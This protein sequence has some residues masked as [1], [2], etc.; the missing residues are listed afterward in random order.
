[1]KPILLSIFLVL[2]VSI[3]TLRAQSWNVSGNT[4]TTSY[5]LGTT[6]KVSLRVFTNNTQRMVVDSLGKVGIG[7]AAPNASAL[8][9]ITSTSKGLLI[10]RMTTAQRSAITSP[11]TGLLVYQTDGTTGFYYYNAG[12]KAVTPALSGFASTALSNLG[13]TTAINVSLLPKTTFISDL[14]S[15]TKQWKNLYMGGDVYIW[16][17]RFISDKAN[18]NNFFG[19]NAGA[20]TDINSGWE[21]T[22]IGSEALYRNSTGFYNTASGF[23]ALYLNT[24]GSSNTASG[25]SALYFNTIGSFNTASGHQAMRNNTTGN[26]NVADGSRALNSNTTGSNNTASGYAALYLNTSGDNNT[27]YGFNAL[28][29]NSIGTDNVAI[30]ESALISNT[31]GSSNTAIGESAL[32]SNTEG[33]GNTASG[34]QALYSNHFGFYNTA[35]GHQALYSNTIGNYNTAIG[36]HAL[37]RNTSSFNTAIGFE[38]L[39]SNTSGS[40]NT[41]IGFEALYSD[42]T[43]SYNTAV[44]F[45]AAVSA[46]S[47]TNATSLGAYTSA[48]SD[49]LDNITAV[50]Y[51]ATALASNQVMLGNTSVTSVKAAG[52][53]VVYSDGRFKKDI[54]EDVPGLEFINALRPVT[55]HYNIHDLNIHIRP[56]TNKATNK[57][58]ND[59]AAQLAAK[60]EEEAVKAKEKILYTGFVAQE[61]EAAAKKLNYDFSGVYKPANDKDVYGLSYSDFVVPLVKA[62][63]QLSK[64]NEELEKKSERVDELEARVTKLEALLTSNNGITLNNNIS[65]TVSLSAAY[66]EQNTPNPAAGSTTLIK[67]FVPA[68]ISNAKIVFTDMKGSIVKSVNV[69][70]GS[71]QVIVNY[72]TLAAGTYHYALYLDGKQADT[73][74]MIIAR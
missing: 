18:F 29:H 50:G 31:D 35:S 32:Y 6:N 12:W 60:Q 11:A 66:L 14:G 23:R 49:G 21:N 13:A 74:T 40:F 56:A 58:T 48:A 57:G 10:P 25:D 9:D 64:K 67:Y 61:V 34:F 19:T 70:K 38:A 1:M 28:Y 39:Y 30:G 63:Q 73:K 15:A 2:F 44:G 26:F 4:A 3:H 62:V 59:Q 37:Y 33:L 53:F 8:L 42:T 69:T 47:C 36:H 16:G 43:S 5:K 41:A 72:G 54:K 55:Y 71:G 27:A 22:G 68:D 17:N 65:T 51:G 46:A 24:T 20:N 45:G 52:S 7:T